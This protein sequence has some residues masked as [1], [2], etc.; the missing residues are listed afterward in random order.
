MG[1]LAGM[2]SFVAWEES[3]PFLSHSFSQPCFF[4]PSLLSTVNNTIFDILELSVAV[5]F[6]I[7]AASLAVSCHRHHDH[8]LSFV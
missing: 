3:E 7:L 6:V 4:K 8:S 2:L 1:F 5:S